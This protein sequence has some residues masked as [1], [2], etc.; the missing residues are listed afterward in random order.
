[1]LGPSHLQLFHSSESEELD[2]VGMNFF[3]PALVS[4][5]PLLAHHSPEVVVEKK[6]Y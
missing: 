2:N 1:M 6:S 3:Q 4:V 5:Q